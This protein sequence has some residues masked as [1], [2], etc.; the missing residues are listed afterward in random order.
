MNKLEYGI[1]S[2]GKEF[3]DITHPH[4]V[5]LLGVSGVGKS[6]LLHELHKRDPRL[7][8]NTVWTNRAPRKED[9]GR[10]HLP[11]HA[12]DVLAKNGFILTDSPAYGNRY[13]IRRDEVERTLANKRIPMQDYPIALVPEIQES[14][15]PV[16]SIYIA[17]PGIAEW[18]QRLSSDERDSTGSRFEIGLRELKELSA[19]G[20]EDPRIDEVVIND[21]LEI[22]VPRLQSLI[23][24]H[25]SRPPI[26]R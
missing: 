10:K 11:D 24:R 19:T 1:S 7:E 14:A 20:Y 8:L 22:A 25:V 13:V 15:I 18:K 23:Y 3:P 21:R 16:L 12:I 5:L 17:P 6:T 2:E 26:L 9:V 4:F